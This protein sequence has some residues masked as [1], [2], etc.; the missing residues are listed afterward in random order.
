MSVGQL[1]LTF[2]EIAKETSEDAVLKL[3]YEQVRSDWIDY[4]NY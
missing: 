1:S 2:H 4:K 3:V